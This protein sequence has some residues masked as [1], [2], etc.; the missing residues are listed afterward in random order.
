[1]AKFKAPMDF[2]GL[3][4]KKTFKKGEEFDMTVKRAEELEKNINEKHPELNFKLE[5]L[6]KPENKDKE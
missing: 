6:D 2:E 3:K 1:M 4:E 5:R